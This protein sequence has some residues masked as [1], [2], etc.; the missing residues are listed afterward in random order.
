MSNLIN[1]ARALDDQR[2]IWRVRA[3]MLEAASYH[4]RAGATEDTSVGMYA[5]HILAN[6]MGEDRRMEALCATDD[7]VA[8]AVTVDEWSTVN[9]EGVTDAQIEAAVAANWELA[10]KLTFPQVG[11]EG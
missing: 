11:T 4:I 2:F 6:P 10:A 7:A 5:R 1:T 8:A 9:T 3:A